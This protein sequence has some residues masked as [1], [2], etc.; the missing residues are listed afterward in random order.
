MTVL[1]GTRRRSR[2][3]LTARQQEVVTLRYEC[4]ASIREIAV[5]LRIT[6]RAVLYRLGNARR[7]LNGRARPARGKG[8]TVAASQLL[9]RAYPGGL[10]LDES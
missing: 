3:P 1:S 7:R 10:N 2:L 4:G 8:K 9:P 6:R 5:W